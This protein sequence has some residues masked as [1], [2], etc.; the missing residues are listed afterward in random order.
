M[1]SRYNLGTYYTMPVQHNII[2]LDKVP[3]SKILNF[4]YSKKINLAVKQNKNIVLRVSLSQHIQLSA[5]EKFALQQPQKQFFYISLS[6]S[7]KL[8]TISLISTYV[9]NGQ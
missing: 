5:N 4:M 6:C 9:H 1:K 8:W 2:A 3:G 7:R